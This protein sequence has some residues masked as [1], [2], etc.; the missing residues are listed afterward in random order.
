MKSSSVDVVVVGAGHAGLSIS[1]FLND[2]AIPHLLFERNRIGD[3]WRNSR[4]D[5]FKMNTPNQ[6]NVLPGQD[7]P[8]SERE[9]FCTASDF[10]GL[11]EKYA[12]RLQLPV[13]E[14]AKVLSMSKKSGSGIFE[15]EI[16]VNGS[17]QTYRSKQVIVASGAFCEKKLPA[18]IGKISP[19][20]LQLHAGDFRNV[21]QLP[22]GAVLVVGSAQSGMQIAEDLISHGKKVILSTSQVP[23]VPRRYRGR[24]IFEWFVL[25]G[26]ND[27]QASDA[28]PQIMEIKQPQ[29]SNMGPRGSS[30]SYQSLARKGAVI[31]GKLDHV[32]KLDAYFQPNAAAHIHYAD[33]FS[34][35]IKDMV[36]NYILKA[37][38]TAPHPEP[39][40]DDIPDES[41]YYAS[42]IGN[43][44]LKK[45]QITSVIWATGFS[46]SF[47]YM[48]IPVFDD[49]GKPQHDEGI[50]SISGLY[51]LGLPWLRKRKSGIINGIGED[52][53]L[54]AEKIKA[55]A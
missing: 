27:M 44:N 34:R 22:E 2:L 9:G 10:A 41:A 52:A 31:L 30:L 45:W 28:G 48:K 16:E 24:D 26:F 11:L 12:L 7:N 39:D 47:S 37:K 40:H 3:S 17:L 8:F 5:S 32:D 42:Q 55:Y 4:W 29:V 51:F 1:Y 18:R 6:Y 15:L 33:E 43:L 35:K 25:S 19:D 54:L 50:S 36:D 20:I 49:R 53:A 13:V 14:Q 46:P 21:T 23:R 38:I